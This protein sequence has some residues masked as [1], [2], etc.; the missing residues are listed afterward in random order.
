M[1]PLREQ[2][3]RR[4]PVLEM[5]DE[6]GADTGE[7]A[8]PD[9]RALPADDVRCRSHHR[10][11]H[12]LRSLPG[13]AGGGD[14]G[15]L[16]LRHR[17]SGG[18]AHRDLLRRAC[19]A[20]PV[21]GSSYSY[22]YATLG[23]LPAMGVAACLLL[24][25]GVSAAAVAVGW[26]QYLNEL[27][28]S[29]FAVTLPESLSQAP[30][31]G[32]ILNLP[33]V[34]LVFLCTLLLIRGERAS[35][36]RPTRSWC[37]SSWACWDCSSSWA[38][39]LELRQL[40]ELRAVRYHRDHAAGIIFFSY[41]GL[42]AVSTAGEEVKDPHRNMPLAILFALVIVTAVYMLVTV[43]AVAASSGRSR[44]RRRGSRRSSSRSPAP[45]GRAPSWLRAR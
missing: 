16:V 42:D 41:I 13:C 4:K 40:P 6:T 26:S 14:R 24:E 22:A 9:H 5:E 44:T 27:L 7:R 29:L 45:L 36:R 30:E 15:H 18:R 21:S 10:H 20:V 31:Q 17:R 8:R 2:I 34:I 33:A 37:S 12:L 39:R 28:D 1:A 43:V 35:P 3:L 23:E 32:G 25:Y 38:S 19:G 11:R